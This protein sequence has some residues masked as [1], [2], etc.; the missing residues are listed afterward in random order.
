MNDIVQNVIIILSWLESRI[1]AFNSLFSSLQSTRNFL[2]PFYIKTIEYIFKILMNS[3]NILF[4]YK[5]IY[6]N[7]LYHQTS[8]VMGECCENLSVFWFSFFKNKLFFFFTFL[9]IH[10]FVCNNELTKTHRVCTGRRRKMT[11]LYIF[12][13]FFIYSICLHQVNYVFYFSK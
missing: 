7:I 2:K 5:S 8:H 13:E 6:L 1:F 11:I 4:I 9:F 12:S 3:F 10:S